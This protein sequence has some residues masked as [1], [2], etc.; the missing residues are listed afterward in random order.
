MNEQSHLID[1]DMMTYQNDA[2]DSQTESELDDEEAELVQA[3]KQVKEVSMGMYR[4]YL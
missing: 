2:S 1:D 3:V 4:E